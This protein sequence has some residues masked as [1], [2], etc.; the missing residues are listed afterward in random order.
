[1][2][3]K[4]R[5]ALLVVAL[6]VAEAS[7]ERLSATKQAAPAEAAARSPLD[8]ARDLVEQGQLD[9]ALAKLGELP[10]DA[11]SL[12]LQGSVWA[13]KAEA[14]PLPTPAPHSGP[15]PRGAEPPAAPEFKPE[16]LTALDLFERAAAARPDHAGAQL[17][18]AELLAPHAARLQTR[19]DAA[20]RVAGRK[21]KRSTPDAAPPPAGDAPDYRADRVIEAYRTAMQSDPASWQA[22]QGLA[23]FAMRVGR[24]DE[25]DAAF[26]ELIRRDKE[27]PEQLVRYGDFLASQ[28]KDPMAAVDYYRQA[29]IWRPDDDET[30]GKVADVFIAIGVEHFIKQEFAVAEA[31]F[32]EAEKYIA[33]R[34]S[35]RGIKIQDYQGRLRSIRTKGER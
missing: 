8:D 5:P 4:T 19:L 18:I 21:G 31:R 10:S 20:Q 16:E 34:G 35:P 30:R 2:M 22:A 6:A 24:L 13:R 25:A 17:A 7:C 15:L 11:E 28:R 3:A 1:M 29:L 14:A 23:T 12:Y 27:N 33:D 26:R 9:G 32:T